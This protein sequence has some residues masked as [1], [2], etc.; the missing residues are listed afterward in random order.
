MCGQ[1]LIDILIGGVTETGFVVINL[2]PISTIEEALVD[3]EECLKNCRQAAN[4]NAAVVFDDGTCLNTNF[5]GGGSSAVIPG[6]ISYR[7][8]PEELA[9]KE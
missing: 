4:C 3:G 2:D 1:F 9:E 6:A 5:N 8:C 7:L